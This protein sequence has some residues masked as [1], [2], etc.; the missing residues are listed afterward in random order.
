MLFMMGVSLYA[1]RIILSVLGIEDF[2]IY[3]VVGGIITIF[4]F[5]NSSL[6]GATSR[7]LTFEIGR[8]DTVRMQRVFSGSLNIHIGI[9]LFIFILAETIGLW[10]FEN[11]LVIPADR[12]SAAR[13]VYQLSI[14]SSMISVTQIPYNAAIIAHERM[15]VFAFIGI[16]EASLKLLIVFLLS[17]GSFDRLVF[18]SVLIFSTTFIIASIYRFYC[19]RNLKECLYKFSIDMEII[20]PMISFSL[21]DL[22]GNFCVMAGYQGVNI[23]QNLFFGPVINAA[24]G[25]AIQ[26]QSAIGNF[27]SNFLMSVRPQIVKNFATNDIDEM[28][29]LVYNSSKYSF[30]LLLFFSL[31]LIIENKFILNLWLIKVPHYAVVFC[32]IA[33]VSNLISSLFNPIAMAIHATGQIK[34]ISFISGSIYIITIPLSYVL[35]KNGFSPIYPFVVNLILLCIASANN[36]LILRRYLN[37][38]SIIFFFRKVVSIIIIISLVSSILPTTLM[39]TL[40]DGW[41]RFILV[42]LTSC[43]SI[44]SAFY[45][46]GLNKESRIEIV[47]FIQRKIKR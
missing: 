38:F 27:V 18:Y 25:I 6:S 12:M 42:G 29:K 36:L 15:N 11:K 31:P 1:S 8:N 10:F 23:I 17:L 22:Y 26:V 13:I 46:I 45:F 43:I 33:L 2:G 35:L 7:F 9:A 21:W 41:V 3:S 39:I 4:S 34:R 37:E 16:I 14:I 32:Q 20:K 5:L 44:I 40:T 47:D 19:V 24:S 28:L 30:I